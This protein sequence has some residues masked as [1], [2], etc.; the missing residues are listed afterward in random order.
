MKKLFLIRHAKSSWD[1]PSLTDFL[2]PLNARGLRDAPR[3]AGI[4]AR[5]HPGIDLLLHSPA[6]R[7]TE[8][9][10]YFTEALGNNN[11][12]V[13]AI[14]EIYDAPLSDLKLIVH[15][16][17]DRFS[18]VVMIGH[19]PGMSMLLHYFTDQIYDMPTCAIAEIL[20]DQESWKDCIGSV[21]H[22]VNFDY[23]KKYFTP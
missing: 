18:Q 12:Q 10:S 16:L 4:L 17:D 6:V 20:F 2:R 5:S 23:P 13:L 21:G 22:L 14:P 3:M 9:A 8:T 11:M 19:N 1:D 7:T 15:S